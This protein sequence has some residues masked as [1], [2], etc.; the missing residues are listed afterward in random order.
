MIQEIVIDPTY[1][2]PDIIDQQYSLR[3]IEDKVIDVRW[4]NTKSEI[5]LLSRFSDLNFRLHVSDIAMQEKTAITFGLP[6]E[7]D[8]NTL[9]TAFLALNSRKSY[10][11]RNFTADKPHTYT[12]NL[13]IR[14]AAD[15]LRRGNLNPLTEIVGSFV[16][17]S[18]ISPVDADVMLRLK[19]LQ[20]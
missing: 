15:A 9:N 18:S 16:Q 1:K 17:K 6:V 11:W 2:G 7:Y 4:L 20:G 10:D 14:L 8:R 19:A 13:L 5:T 3:K 12:R